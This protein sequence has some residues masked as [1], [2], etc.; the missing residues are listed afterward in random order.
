MQTS[1]E[2]NIS[3]EELQLATRNHGMPLE[4]LRRDLTPVGLHYLLIHY[5]VPFVDEHAYRLDVDGEVERPLTLTIHDLRARSAA[6][7][8]VTMECA[9]N[10]RARFTPRP[11]SQPWL[12]EAVG[13]AAWRGVPLRALLDEA[14]VRDGVREVL[15][16]GL[17]R[18][19]EKEVEQIYQRSLS[20]DEALRDELVLAY[21]MNG[22]P[23]LPQHG[24]PLRLVVPGWYGMTNVKWLSQITALSE[25]FEGYQQSAAY[26][27]RRDEEDDGTPVTRMAPRA[28]MVPPGIP[29]FHTRERTVSPG[30]CTLEG[31]AWSGRA[32]IAGVD[33]STDRGAT[34]EAAQLGAHVNSSPWAWCSWTYDWDAETGRHELCCR[35]RD[36]A[37]NKQPLDAEWNVGGYSNNSVQRVIVNV[38]N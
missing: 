20:L 2:T 7:V 32:R 12:H 33:V 27:F 8:T 30:R 28:L 6:E 5:D 11:F 1:V 29:D 10:G 14:G 23:L 4:A 34:W 16:T 24:A 31:R 22:A 9:G 21:E 38:T 18:G 13:T 25:P 3:L 15:F 35:A 26:K 37:G 36:E 19:I 17:D